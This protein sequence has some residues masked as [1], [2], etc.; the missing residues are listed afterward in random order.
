MVGQSA[1][2][3]ACMYVCYAATPRCRRSYSFGPNYERRSLKA[4]FELISHRFQRMGIFANKY[5]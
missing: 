4:A 5:N 3:R 2:M 1:C